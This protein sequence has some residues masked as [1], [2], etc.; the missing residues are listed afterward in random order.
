[1]TESVKAAFV[2]EN[3]NLAVIPG[4]LTSIL[5]PLDVALNKPFKDGVRKFTASGRQKKP[6][7]ELIISWIAAA[8]NDIPAEMVESSF[9][10]CGITN[11]LD[12]S[13]DD[14]VYENSEELIDDDSFFREMFESDSESDFEGFDI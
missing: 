12:G 10:K 11:N 1:M 3:T 2:R 5:Q 13:E 6:S 8:W 9:L 14:L 7:E 4:V